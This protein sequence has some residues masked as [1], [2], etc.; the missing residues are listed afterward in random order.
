[1]S[2]M[3]FHRSPL[4]R[5]TAIVTLTAFLA[6]CIPQNIAERG[7]AIANGTAAISSSASGL[8]STLSSATSAVTDITGVEIP[9]SVKDAKA[10]RWSDEDQSAAAE[11]RSVF[12]GEQLD[13]LPVYDPLKPGEAQRYRAKIR[14]LS[15]K[16]K[17]RT[18]LTSEEMMEVSRVVVPVMRY[19]AKSRTYRESMKKVPAIKR[20]PKGHASVT[21]PAGM[22]MEIALLTY[23]NDHGLPAP[24]KGEKLQLRDSSL[25]M[26]QALRPVFSDLHTYAATHP[27]AHY[28]MQQTVWW[29]R[30]TPCQPEKLS[31]RQKA[32]IEAARPGGMA[33]LQ[34]YCS[35]EKMKGQLMSAGNRFIPGVSAASGMLSEYQQLMAA[36]TDYSTKAQAFLNADLTNPADILALAQ[37]SGLTD[38]VGANRALRDPSLQRLAPV[39]QQ[40]GLIK[41]LI[42]NSVDDKAV[43]TSLSVMEELGRQL[44]AQQGVDPTGISNFSKLENGLYVDST[45][46]GGASNAFVKVRNT[47]TSD[48]EF[49]GSDY[50]L[51]S[52]D[53]PNSAHKT[54]RPT[55]ALSIGP[56]QPQ[57]IYPNEPDAAKRYTTAKENEAID[58]LK[59]LEIQAVLESVPDEK[60]KKQCEEREKARPGNGTMLYGDFK[61]GIIRDVVQTIPFLGNAVYAYSAFTGKDWMTGADLST[62]DIAVA[63]VGATIPMAGAV[64]GLKA[65]L[66]LGQALKGAIWKGFS[67]GDSLAGAATIGIRGSEGVFSLKGDDA[68]TAWAAGTS[69]LATYGCDRMNRTA[70]GMATGLA[71]LAGNLPQ[72]RRETDAEVIADLSARLEYSLG[73][74][75]PKMW[76]PPI[77]EDTVGW[78][79]G[80][81]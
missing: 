68:C 33:E 59:D 9:G 45:T 57:R 58:F 19:L 3:S 35:R 60:V 29:L 64:S 63:F 65:G 11:S 62:A 44:G 54:Y 43:A 51:T 24:W 30:D 72:A 15:K 74:G 34:A 40:S 14:E 39:L 56:M 17:G 31:E 78:L 52:V 38:M 32:M 49:N 53:D 47:T 6:G 75:G 16:Y 27:N 21:V 77:V 12:L 55:Q 79:K 73:T 42:P 25:Y 26:P 20:D 2:I 46:N 80:L 48:L 71:S 61:L 50:V 28:L 5:A 13:D 76:K 22:T 67:T 10:R 8:L 23:C 70:C 37:T 18:T 1:M 41:A 69:A 66:K 81:F 7:G 36:A 4:T